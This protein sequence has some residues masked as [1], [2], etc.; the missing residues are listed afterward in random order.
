MIPATTVHHHPGGEHMHRKFEEAKREEGF[1]LI[2]LLVVV[3]IIGILAAIAIPIFLNQRERAWVRTAQSDAR[4]IAIE[5]E[6]FFNDYFVYPEA[7]IPD[8]LDGTSSGDVFPDALDN[9]TESVTGGDVVVS[10][11]ITLT[12]EAIGDDAFCVLADHALLD[13][14]PN[15]VYRSDTGGIVTADQDALDGTG[16][17]DWAP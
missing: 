10:P 3:I 1:T 15:A 9:A 4:N 16:C 5:V 11:N 2:E 13:V 14:S 6:S 17:A 8:P 7:T 12:Y